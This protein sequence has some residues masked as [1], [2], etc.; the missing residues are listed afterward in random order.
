MDHIGI[1]TK[2]SQITYYGHFSGCIQ[3][4]EKQFI[5]FTNMHTIELQ[6]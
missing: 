6:I 3:V 2:I 5:F 4:D 1:L